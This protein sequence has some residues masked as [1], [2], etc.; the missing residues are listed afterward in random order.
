VIG[1][2]KEGDGKKE[3][4]F[5]SGRGIV[6]KE[7]ACAVTE[8]DETRKDFRQKKKEAA[9]SKGGEKRKKEKVSLL[10]NR[11]GTKKDMSNGKKKKGI[12]P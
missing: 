1:C 10:R 12:G 11:M 3:S 6:Q 4:R 5:T 8:I 7:R 9:L 2:R